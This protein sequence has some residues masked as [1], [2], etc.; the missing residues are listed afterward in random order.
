MLFPCNLGINMFLNSSETLTQNLIENINLAFDSFFYNIFLSNWSL[1]SKDL[2]TFGRE[3]FKQNSIPFK[4]T[5][6]VYPTDLFYKSLNKIQNIRYLLPLKLGITHLPL[7]SS[8]H[9]NLIFL[10]GEAH[11]SQKLALV[12]TYNLQDFE[13]IL[14]SKHDIL[15]K[16]IIKESI[17]EI[18]HIILGVD[19]CIDTNCVMNYSRNLEK[20]D[21]KSIFLC[22]S[23]IEKLEEIRENYNF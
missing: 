1:D 6:L 11:I 8:T 3:E 5:V 14:H 12:S 13:T 4:E 10:Y 9:S 16:R 23:C 19:H 17:H 21:D 18:G 15:E 2:I 7:Y 22:N 20:V